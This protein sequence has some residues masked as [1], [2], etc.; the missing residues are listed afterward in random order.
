VPKGRIPLAGNRRKESEGKKK[1]SD[2]VAWG[3]KVWEPGKRGALAPNKIPL[4]GTTG[5]Q[6]TSRQLPV[7]NSGKTEEDPE[8][9]S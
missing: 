2:S 8:G 5:G 9:G 7:L 6:N 4:G 1:W 3:E